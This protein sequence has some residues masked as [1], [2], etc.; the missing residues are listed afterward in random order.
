MF[1]VATAAAPAA[2]AVVIVPV[3]GKKKE[4]RKTRHG[5]K[6]GK[7]VCVVCDL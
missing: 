7:T 4:W 1:V 3:V 6:K 5:K 2:P